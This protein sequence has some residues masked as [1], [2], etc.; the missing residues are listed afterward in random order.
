MLGLDNG[1][2][3]MNEVGRRQ[4][5]IDDFSHY[6]GK[7]WLD[8]WQGKDQAH[9]TLALTEAREGRKSSFEGFSPTRK[10]APRWWEV[11]V[12]PVCLPDGSIRQLLAVSRDI[13]ER[14]QIQDF[15]KA[16][17]KEAKAARTVAEV[18]T[19]T[20]REARAF[21]EIATATANEARIVA[22]SA[23]LAKS[24]FLAN[25][26]HEIRTPMNA[27]FG[28]SNILAQSQPLTERQKE[29]VST[30]QLSATSLLA[31]IND[32]LHIYKI[33]SRSAALENV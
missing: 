12:T 31:L 16:A 3:S 14:V 5:E 18:A 17:L 6:L 13:T 15:L 4:M 28:L 26:S 24:E 2:L 20:A 23:N 30:L 8:F 9:A 32:L 21:A 1:L 22:D 33:E 27:V 7:P 11:I 19:A 29:Y 10:G 25:M